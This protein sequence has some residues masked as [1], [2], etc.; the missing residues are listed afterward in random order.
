MKLV[1]TILYIMV[2]L[3][4]SEKQRRLHAA[5]QYIDTHQSSL[6][7]KNDLRISTKTYYYVPSAY[8]HKAVNDLPENVLTLMAYQGHR[9]RS[10]RDNQRSQMNASLGSF[11]SLNLDKFIADD[12]LSGLPNND[13]LG[14]NQ[15]TASQQP[16]QQVQQQQQ[17]QLQVPFDTNL[18][19]QPMANQGY[20]QPPL[21]HQVQQQGQPQVPFDTNFMVQPMTNQGCAQPPPQQ[22][23][24]PPLD[25]SFMAQLMAQPM[26]NQGYDTQQQQQVQFD[27]G[28]MTIYPKTLS[29]LMDVI[30]ASIPGIRMNEEGTVAALQNELAAA[31][32]RITELE[33]EA[34]MFK[35][36]AHIVKKQ[37]T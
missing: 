36:I 11:N 35:E 2:F 37:R 16:F 34:T 6:F 14:T 13:G 17:G 31:K 26:V 18:I 21:Q 9:R 24:Q 19:A 27:A 3:T 22:P 30:N 7:S 4:D 10:S 29:E 12:F 25:T 1:A 20:T 5:C 23:A 28:L 15:V 33:Q 32:R 8:I